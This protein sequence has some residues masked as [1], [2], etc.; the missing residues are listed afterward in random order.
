MTRLK[1]SEWKKFRLFYITNLKPADRKKLLDAWE[2]FGRRPLPPIRSQFSEPKSRIELDVAVLGVLGWT[3]EDA[4]TLLEG[5]HSVMSE[6]IGR[7]MARL[8]PRIKEEEKG[9]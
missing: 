6:E 1:I 9:R 8:G 4:R 5:I 3:D 2:R 7:P